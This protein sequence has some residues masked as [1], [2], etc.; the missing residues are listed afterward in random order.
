M[1][2]EARAGRRE[3]AK[4]ERGGRETSKAQPLKAVDKMAA[5]RDSCS[6]SVSCFVSNS[7]TKIMRKW[8][9][10][11]DGDAGYSF[12]ASSSV[13]TVRK[14]CLDDDEDDLCSRNKGSRRPAEKM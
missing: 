12:W 3:E 2:S 4:R 7:I 5:E 9:E 8:K 10:R 11:V 14:R 13:L 6:S 1:K